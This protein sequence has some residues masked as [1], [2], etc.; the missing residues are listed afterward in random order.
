[1]DA[2]LHVHAARP[3]PASRLAGPHRGRPRDP[4]RGA[5]VAGVLHRRRQGARACGVPARRGAPARSGAA[6]AL[7][8][9]LL[10]VRG[11]RP[12]SPRAAWRGPPPPE[13]YELPVFYFS[14]PAAVYGPERQDP[15]PGRRGGA[16]LRARARGGDRRRRRDRRLHDHERLVGAGSPAR[17]RWRSGSGPSK[18]KDF[19]TSL[20][21]VLVTADELDGVGLR[22]GRARERRGAFARQ[23][24]R[25]A[26]LVAGDRR[27]RGTEHAS[28]AGGRARFGDRRDAVHPRARRRALAAARRRRG[29]G[30]RG[31][32]RAAEHGRSQSP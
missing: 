17:A 5:D 14:N 24:A 6:A 25:H 21:P 20:G 16:R 23:L 28:R 29:A 11:A 30:G 26:P 27:A 3:R 2:P 8:P 7:D 13:W 31:H 22:D 15:V 18:G 9:R 32:R 4:A 1:M 19:A 12:A 10:R